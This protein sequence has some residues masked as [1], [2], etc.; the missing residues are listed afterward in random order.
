[1]NLATLAILTFTTLVLRSGERLDVQGIAREHEGRIIFRS[2]GALYSIPL[3]EIDPD[4]TRAAEQ[5][6]IEPASDWRRLKVSPEHRDRLLRELEKN[7]AGQ[8][9][10]PQK[11]LE[12]PPREPVAPENTKEEWEWRNAARAREESIRRAQENLDLLHTRA[13][14]LN[15]EIL[16]LF[17]L[18]YKPRQFT[19]QL[20]QLTMI[21]E[22]IPYAELEVTRA[23]RAWDQFRDDARR[24]NVLPGWL[25]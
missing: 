7:H 15:Q 9:P 10:A 1:M 23:K 5:A 2:G 24:Q 8:P 22:Q 14:R 21:R 6:R 4:A 13:E 20:S 17:S 25:R 18:G 11:L 3:T 12:E 19:Y 16:T